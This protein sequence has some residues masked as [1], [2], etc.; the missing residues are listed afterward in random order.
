MGNLISNENENENENLIEDQEK[1]QEKTQE[2]QDSDEQQQ[3]FLKLKDELNNRLK[4]FNI[5]ESDYSDYFSKIEKNFN[6]L[7]KNYTIEIS[8]RFSYNDYYT[9]YNT[10]KTQKIGIKHICFSI[11]RKAIM[12][13]CL[14]KMVLSFNDRDEFEKN[15]IKLFNMSC[16]FIKDL[17]NDDYKIPV[18]N[19]K[20][21]S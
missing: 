7:H 15:T 21:I 14:K 2:E 11:Y 10:D 12:N 6:D 4:K 20:T 19:W 3:A 13:I 18:Y 17:E 9:Y 16:Q 8:I 1:N 5:K